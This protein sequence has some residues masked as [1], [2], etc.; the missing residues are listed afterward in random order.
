MIGAGA[1]TAEKA[2]QFI[3]DGLLDAVAFGRT[4]LANPDL[5]E[6]FAQDAALNEMSQVGVYGGHAE[7]Y[8]DYPRLS[9]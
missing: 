3:A 5:P 6:R 8:I 2:S 9:A 1:Y 4:F 7:G